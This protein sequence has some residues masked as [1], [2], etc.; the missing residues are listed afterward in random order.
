MPTHTLHVVAH[1]RV[2]SGHEDAGRAVLTALLEPTRREPGC[3][4]Y[5]LLQNSSDPGDFTFVEEWESDAALDA[6]LATPHV[7]AALARLRPLLGAPPDIR[8]YRLVG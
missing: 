3:I 8:R 6:H 2:E 7:Q 5:E 4:R 1:I